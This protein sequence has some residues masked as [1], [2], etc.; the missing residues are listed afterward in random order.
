VLDTRGGFQH[1]GEPEAAPTIAGNY[2]GQLPRAPI[3]STWSNS[4]GSKSN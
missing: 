4:N 2:R 1:Y 3:E